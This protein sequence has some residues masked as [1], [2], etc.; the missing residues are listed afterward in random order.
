MKKLIFMLLFLPFISWG[1]TDLAELL[2]KKNT[3]NIPYISV[4]QLKME[5]NQTG[6]LLIFDAR[7]AEEYQVSH[8][9]N[10]KAVGFKEFSIKKIEENYPKKNQEI[11]VYCSLGIRS[12][13]IAQKLKNA[14]YTE[15]KNLYGGIFEWKNNNFPVVDSTQNETNRIHAY[16][17]KWGKWL[18][19]GEKV[20]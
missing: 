16:S 4:E 5:V 10:A 18:K 17:K 19:K 6:S 11:V 2:A 13:K 9:K 20:Y 1:Q 14:G 7:E 8:L 15:V 12:E 3:G